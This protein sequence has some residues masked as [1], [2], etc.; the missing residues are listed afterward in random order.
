MA[1]E[2]SRR[3]ILKTME[4]R[5]LDSA[6]HKRSKSDTEKRLQG[7]VLKSPPAD[8]HL[9]MRKK[10]RN[11]DSFDLK[12]MKKGGGR[13][14]IK[15]KP[16]DSEVQGPLKQEIIQLERRLK[17]Q[18][19]MRRAL[20]KALGY[21]PTAIVSSN[22]SFMPKQAL[23]LIREIAV[24]ELE[25]MHLEQYLLSLYR[26]AFEQQ[27]VTLSPV[28]P[29]ERSKPPI[30]CQR[31][32]FDG[33]NG[34]EISSKGSPLVHS[35]RIL[36][37]QLS[38][39]KLSD[40]SF[41]EKLD[42]STVHR[43]H[44]ALNQRAIYSSRISPSEE[45]L[46]RALQECHSQ[47]LSFLT[48]VKLNFLLDGHDNNSGVISLAEYLGTSVADHVPETPNKVSEDM[49]RCMGAIYSKLADP[50]LVNHGPSFSSPTSSFSST[51]AISP[52]HNGDIW[53]PGCRSEQI[54]DT[55]LINPFRVEGLKEFSGPYN[56]MVEV[57][58]ISRDRW[59]LDNVK[60]LLNIYKLANVNMMKM[61]SDE[62]LAFWINIHNVLAYLVHGVPQSN[63][64]KASVLIKWIR[65]FMLPRI[66]LKAKDEWKRFYSIDEHEPLIHFAL[67]SGSHSDPA[68][69]LYTPKRVHQQLETAKEDYIRATFAV[70][71]EQ[72]ILL[73]KLVDSYAKDK[74]LS[75]QR[76]IDMIRRHLPESLREAAEGCQ[77]GR[78][79]KFI[80]WVPY[81]SSF[82][83][84]LSREVANPHLI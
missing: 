25:V 56:S 27:G 24:L 69:R 41:Y 35:T 22:D 5:K 20:E 74:C 63:M 70:Q 66:K 77:Q 73:P 79:Q 34:P 67:S 36:P 19:F 78:A 75:S 9:K 38:A 4:S 17:D 12:D 10:K 44:S 21:R 54:L 68:V 50:P 16:L 65:A 30:S 46:A 48:V 14:D 26:K 80:E 47:P 8:L 61:K 39:S 28:P 32:L 76:V 71:K 51:S 7:S 23:D 31:K 40:E 33:G 13:I 60:H 3:S 11:I 55:R 52:Q 1:E 15:K 37:S 45:A 43:C 59:R 72:K 2:G 82:R 58:S 49:V 18:L 62:K 6:R 29:S 57:T 42:D 64:K 81:N 83:Y 84:L 53:S